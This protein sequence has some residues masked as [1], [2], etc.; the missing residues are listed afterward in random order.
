MK[1]NIAVDRSASLFIFKWPCRIMT[2]KTSLA[3]P[4]EHHIP[5]HP[6]STQSVLHL[7]LW[8]Y[9]WTNQ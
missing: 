8:L 6:K 2:G 9:Q 3:S 4:D 1:W 5:L 7:S